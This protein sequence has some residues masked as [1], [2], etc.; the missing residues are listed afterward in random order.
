MPMTFNSLQYAAFL[1]TVLV[2]YW[3]LPRR[4]RMP[5]LLVASYVFY[6]AWDYRFLTLIW[7]ST[8]ADYWIG[9]TLGRST[10]EG[11]RRALL[12]A[13][14]SVNLGILASFK[15]F[16]FFVDSAAAL[17]DKVGLQPNLPVIEVLLPVGISFY[18]FQTLSY[19][20]DIYRRR[21]EPCRDPVAFA[22][23]VAYFPQ[24]VAG[25]IE[26]A[27]RLLPALQADRSP[28]NLEQ[29]QSALTLIIF[30]LFKKVVLADQMAPFVE[31]IFA[32]PSEAAGIE[33]VAAL[34]AFS[35]QVYGDFS[36]YTD[37][38]RGTSRL[39]SIDLM[40]NF[41]QPHLSRSITEFWRRWHISLSSWLRDYLYIPLG[42]SRGSRLATSRNLV[43]TMTLAGLWHGAGWTYVLWGAS[44]GLLLVGHRLVGGKDRTEEELSIRDSWRVAGTF[45]LISLGWLLFRAPSLS[46]T[47]EMAQG[48]ASWS[49]EPRS[50][51]PIAQ[52]GVWLAAMFG[53]DL[54]HRK[55]GDRAHRFVV[56]RP[57]LAG[58]CVGVGLTLVLL[59]SGAAAVPFIYFQ[60]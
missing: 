7:I 35:I 42:G 59:Y 55:L 31:E 5:L 39:L 3:S 27:R 32:A 22:T 57:V 11:R 21:M 24:L 50:V 9:L 34:F 53:L 45:A 23:F 48:L 41:Q 43:L 28:P 4:F 29:I 20:F 44:Q 16:G 47:V 38:A 2:L 1:P 17:L 56:Y 60:F 19:T 40:V 33:I 25:P 49:G 18:T 26:R 51:F 10:G 52:V 12:V 37:I 14:L 46:H 8:A 36:G 15:Y 13:S 58:A 54:V 30:G 6:G